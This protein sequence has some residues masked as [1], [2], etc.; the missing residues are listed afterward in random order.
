M[1]VTLLNIVNG[2]KPREIAAQVLQR[3]EAGGDFVENLLEN[4]L[5]RSRLSPADRGLCQ[6]IV[7]GVVRWHAPL[8]WLITR[9]TN[10]RTQKGML[11]NLLRLGLY[12]IFWL[13]RIPNHAA[14]NET[15]ELARHSGFGAQSGFVNAVLRNYLREFDATKQLLA[16]LKK[17]QPHLGYSHPEWLVARWQKKFGTDK[18]AQL[19]EWNNTPPK[20]FA[21]V[22]MLKTDAGKLLP[23]W[24]DENVEYDFVRRDWL[25]ENLVFELKSHPPLMQLPSFGTHSSIRARLKLSGRFSFSGAKAPAAAL[26]HEGGGPTP[27]RTYPEHLSVQ[28]R[29]VFQQQELIYSNLN[30]SACARWLSA[31][32][33][34]LATESKI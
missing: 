20:T 18:A 4:A 17:T 23:Q 14:V 7:Y 5:A 13:D 9:K 2:Q 27:L 33:S 3:R 21:R 1:D 28:A 34:G 22:N 30:V 6:E 11:Q 10:G 32:S 25:E 8:D 16:D 29:L 24:R 15:V 26:I 19:M 12:Q 31:G